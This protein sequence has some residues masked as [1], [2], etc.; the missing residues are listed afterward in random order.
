MFRHS[1][2]FLLMQP[3]F[4]LLLPRNSPYSEAVH[5]PDQCRGNRYAPPEVLCG[6][7]FGFVS[8]SAQ[9]GDVDLEG[10]ITQKPQQLRFCSYLGGHEVDDGDFQR[11]NVLLDSAIFRHHKDV[12]A[13]KR[14]TGGKISRNLDGHV[15]D[16]LQQSSLTWQCVHCPYGPSAGY[17]FWAISVN[18]SPPVKH[19]ITLCFVKADFRYFLHG[20][21]LPMYTSCKMSTIVQYASP[22]SRCCLRPQ[23]RGA[24]ACPARRSRARSCAV[25]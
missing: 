18:K 2:P 24:P 15:D 16:P 10:R 17:G 1:L 4:G 23:W 19:S 11:T 5:P 8:F 25:R 7:I 6:S 22:A 9:Q 12:F 14:C 3:R 21:F 13:F 20:H